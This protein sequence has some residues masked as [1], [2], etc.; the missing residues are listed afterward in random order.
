MKRLLLFLPLLLCASYPRYE[1]TYRITWNCDGCQIDVINPPDLGFNGHQLRDSWGIPV[2]GWPTQWVK[3][4][5]YTTRK[6]KP[7]ETVKTV[8]R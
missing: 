7:N 2:A 4:Q 5:D 3:V 8:S 6:E 1:V